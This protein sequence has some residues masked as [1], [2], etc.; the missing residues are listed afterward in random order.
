MLY[1][2]SFS[3][4]ISKYEN[5]SRNH[6]KA[7]CITLKFIT[8][9]QLFKARVEIPVKIWISFHM[10]KCL[11]SVYKFYIAIFVYEI[12]EMCTSRQLCSI[13]TS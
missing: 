9:S 5:L 12:H 2:Y 13:H 7:V 3:H 6:Y 4:T 1:H 11:C 8:D 10:Y